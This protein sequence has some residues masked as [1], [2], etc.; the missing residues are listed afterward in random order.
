MAICRDCDQEMKTADGC[1]VTELTCQGE[2]FPTFPYGRDPG[3]PATHARCG[4]CGARRG[5]HH[6]IGCD[7]QR[8]PRCRGQ[9]ISC[10]CRFDQLADEYEDEEDDETWEPP[11]DAPVVDLA[12]WATRPAPYPGPTAYRLKVPFDD[13]AAP[14]RARHRGLIRVIVEEALARGRTCDPD[15]AAAC[16]DALEPH[17]GPAGEPLDR[18]EVNGLLFTRLRNWTTFRDTDLPDGW[19]SDLWTVLTAL[20]ARWQLAPDSDPIAVLLEPLA[21]YGRVGLDGEPM[22]DGVD[23]DFACQCYVPYDPDLPDGI[24]RI[25]VSVRRSDG[26]PMMAVARLQPRAVEVDAS[27]WLPWLAL[28]FRVD[29]DLD[30]YRPVRL[31]P[32]FMGMVA[33]DRHNPALWLYAPANHRSRHPLL[34]LDHDG[35]PHFVRGDRRFRLGYRW[36]PA[37]TDDCGLDV[38]GFH[39]AGNPDWE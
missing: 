5:H 38:A 9:L 17:L 22:L 8:C 7:V 26:E 39:T 24:G 19:I 11:D 37:P 29:A 28:T 35:R 30:R 13:A 16:L 25:I 1:T 32:Q 27:D 34:A 6:H 10:D 2:R 23:V 21:C 15:V 4:D 31:A 36:V 33:A 14:S 12:S 18:P 20:A 3:W